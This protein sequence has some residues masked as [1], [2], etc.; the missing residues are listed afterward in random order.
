LLPYI[1]GMSCPRGPSLF[2]SVFLCFLAVTLSASPQPK[3]IT[4]MGPLFS[5]ASNVAGSAANVENLLP[6]GAS[7][8]DYQLSPKDFRKLD[9]ARLIIFNGLEVEGDLKK[10]LTVD[11]HTAATLDAARGL[12]ERLIPARHQEPSPS[13][14]SGANPHFWLDPTLAAHAVT[15]IMRAMAEADPGHAAAY[16]SNGLSYVQ[17]LQKLDRELSA[18]TAPFK[19]ASIVTHHD[20]FP[21]FA[22]RY[23]L[24]IV[25]VIQEV[26]EV[27]PSPKHLATLQR[28]MREKKVR[29]VFME[30]NS[31]SGHAERIAHDLKVKLAVLDPL[32]SIDLNPT[33]YEDAMRRNLKVLKEMLDAPLP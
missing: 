14:P 5:W 3:V 26:P 6:A 2:A 9:G 19:G 7:P 30:P 13:N 18:G 23:G 11:V 8:H 33:A 17:R 22:R 10:M 15:N 24:Q 27:D 25:G 4:T 32:E 1:P 20:A 29:V 21:Y 28:T 16:E 31:A 12:G